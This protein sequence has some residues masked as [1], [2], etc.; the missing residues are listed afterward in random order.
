MK[1]EPKKPSPVA[2][3]APASDWF[4]DELMTGQPDAQRQFYRDRLLTPARHAVA[5]GRPPKRG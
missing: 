1:I 5:P 3:E 2:G 4:F